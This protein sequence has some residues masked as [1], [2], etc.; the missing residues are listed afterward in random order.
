MICSMWGSA[1]GM[2]GAGNGSFALVGLGFSVGVRGRRGE[3]AKGML[4]RGCGWSRGYV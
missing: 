2:C 1:T 4:W 3:G